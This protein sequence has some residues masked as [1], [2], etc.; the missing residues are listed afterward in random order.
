MITEQSCH[1]HVHSLLNQYG[2]EEHRKSQFI[3]SV[4]QITPTNNY[5][6]FTSMPSD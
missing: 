2:F 4:V 5:V 6:Q 1:F 3:Y